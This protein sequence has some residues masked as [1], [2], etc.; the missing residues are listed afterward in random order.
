MMRHAALA[1]VALVALVG[2]AAPAAAQ[3]EVRS[4]PTLESLG[5]GP[6]MNRSGSVQFGLSGRADLDVY[7][8]GDDPTWLMRE[9]GTFVAPRVRLF[10]DL[11]VGESWFATTEL[12]FD[13]GPVEAWTGYDFRVE[14]AFVRWSPAEL[15]ALQVGRFASPFGSY[16]SRHHTAGDWFIRPPLM[17]EH[18][19]VVLSGQ[20]PASTDGWMLWKDSLSFRERGAPPVWGAPYQWGGMAF[21]ALRDL[22]WRVAYMNSAPAAGPSQW[23]RLDFERG[24]V[25]VAI[26]FRFAPWL[27]AEL[28]HAVGSF[29]G[30]GLSDAEN[31]TTHGPDWFKQQIL[32]GELLFEL[33]HTQVRGEAFHNTWLYVEDAAIDISWS[34]EARQELFQDWFV[35][36]RVGQIRFRR[37]GTSTGGEHWDYNVQ[38]VQAAGGYRLASNAEIRAEYLTQTTD[39]PVDPDDDVIAVQLWWAF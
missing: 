36:G 21:G 19:T 5:V 39:G 24:N 22:S 32:G 1:L 9:T 26:G 37:V 23:D 30:R 4:L 7:R 31:P 35:A 8:T 25:V 14:Q 34:M 18:R 13:H 28:S 27:R 3:D 17:Y 10:G 12:R 15:L 29:L 38:R 6:W 2:V 11:F 33:A 20:V 16:P